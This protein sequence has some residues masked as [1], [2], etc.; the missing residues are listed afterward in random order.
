LVQVTQEESKNNQSQDQVVGELQQKIETHLE[1]EKILKENLEIMEGE[2]NS[3]AAALQD[4]EEGLEHSAQA[5]DLLTQ[6]NE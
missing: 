3:I 5:I 6:S 1:K 4:K 2:V